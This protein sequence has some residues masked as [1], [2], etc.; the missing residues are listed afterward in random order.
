MLGAAL[1]L[2][3]LAAMQCESLLGLELFA[4][5][6]K[7]GG[8]SL[9]FADAFDFDRGCF[10]YLLDAGDP[11]QQLRIPARRHY[12]SLAATFAEEVGAG[13]RARKNGDAGANTDQRDQGT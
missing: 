7:S 2:H 9:A 8:E 4:L 5:R 1:A 11:R 3:R 12:V 13:K 6:Q 10:H